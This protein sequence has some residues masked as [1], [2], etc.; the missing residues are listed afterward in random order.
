M[1]DPSF[2]SEWSVA[3]VGA[4]SDDDGIKNRTRHKSRL[5]KAYATSLIDDTPVAFIMRSRKR[6][7]WVY[8]ASISRSREV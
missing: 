7:T 4:G 1:N 3:S 8:L 5:A 6:W 2:G